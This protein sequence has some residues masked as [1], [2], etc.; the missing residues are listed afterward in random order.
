MT[1]ERPYPNAFEADHFA[2]NRSLENWLRWFTVVFDNLCGISVSCTTNFHR[3]Q[4]FACVGRH[5][6]LCSLRF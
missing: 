3:T 5:F 2:W 4:R 1:M 6:T